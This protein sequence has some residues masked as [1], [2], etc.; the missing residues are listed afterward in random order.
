VNTPAKPADKNAHHGAPVA[1]D[2]MAVRG[3][4]ANRQHDQRVDRQ[5]MDRAPRPHVRIW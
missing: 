3:D 2:D 5:Q 4:D 1:L